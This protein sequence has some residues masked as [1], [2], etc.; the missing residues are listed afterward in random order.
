MKDLTFEE[1]FSWEHLNICFDKAMLGIKWKHSAQNRLAHRIT[2]LTK[3]HND[4]L[5][6]KFK[7][8]LAAD[9]YIRERGKTRE[10]KSVSLED[11]IVQKCLC[12]YY[13]VPRITPKLIYDNSACLK[14]KGYDFAIKRTRHFL[15]EFYKKNK[16]EGY[17]LKFDIHSFFDSIQH[18]ILLE[19]MKKVIID[20]KIFNL[21]KYLLTSLQKDKGM[22]L[23]NQIS[24][25]SGIYYLNELDHYIKDKCGFKYYHRYMDDGI[26]LCE[27][28]AKLNEV[29]NEL[30]KILIDL[31]LEFSPKKTNIIKLSKGFEFLKA[32]FNYSKTGKIIMRPNKKNPVRMRRKIKKMFKNNVSLNNINISVQSW[33]AHLKR[34]DAYKIK[35][36][37]FKLMEN[38]YDKTRNNCNWKTNT[39]EN[40]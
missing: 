27:S 23:G 37:I 14:D 34:F 40:L 29:L 2:I 8:N 28:K 38:E 7:S 32:R 11:R 33:S 18:D 21:Y 35:E 5:T 6:G 12:D 3:L 22:V 31:K 10:I 1:V 16:G 9:F 30:K 4:L 15:A 36:N 13:L 19:K 24:Q 39:I 26:I 20:E 17:V 25:I